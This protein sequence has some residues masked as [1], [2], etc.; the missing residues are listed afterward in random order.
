MA[1]IA[2][3][4]SLGRSLGSRSHSLGPQSTR[5]L[6]SAL[7]FAFQSIP[8]LFRHAASNNSH[9]T[10]HVLVRRKSEFN[11]H[12]HKMIAFAVLIPVLVLLSGLFAGLTLGYMS[13]DETQLNVLSVSG[14]PKQREYAKKIQPIRKNGHLLLVT[15][16]LSNMIVN[17]SLP[18]IADPVLGGGFQSVVVST[19][20]IV[21]FAE[22]I[23][24]SIF[25]RYGLYLGAKLAGLTTV[26]LYTMGIIAWP[27][28]KIL[29]FALGAHH[30]I[31]YRRAELKEL[32]ALHSTTSPHGGDLNSDTVTIIGATLDLQ[33][34]VVKQAMTPIS[35]VFMLSINSILDYET[36]KKI[37]DSGHSRIPVYEEIDTPL[38]IQV[39]ESGESTKGKPTQVISQRVQKIIGILLVKQLVLLD[40]KDAT[41]LRNV[42]LNKVFFVPNNESLLGILDKFQEG[43]SHMAVVSRFSVE[44]AKSVKKAARRGLTQRLKDRVG[45]GDSSDSDSDTEDEESVKDGDE[46]NETLNITVTSEK[47]EEQKTGIQAKD[48]A[49]ANNGDLRGSKGHKSVFQKEQ[50]MPADAVLAKSSANEF[51]RGFDPAIMPLGIITLEDVLEELIGEEIYD[52]FDADG[53]H[54]GTYTNS[55]P[56]VPTIGSIPSKTNNKAT[57]IP[58]MSFK[59]ATSAPTIPKETK[60]DVTIAP[61]ADKLLAVDEQHLTASPDQE[62]QI[63]KAVAE[64][65]KSKSL[66]TTEHGVPATKDGEVL[67]AQPPIEAVIVERKRMARAG[68]VATTTASLPPRSRV[69]GKFKSEPV[70]TGSNSEMASKQGSNSRKDSVAEEKEESPE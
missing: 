49:L 58:K 5:L 26:L 41:P 10:E 24:Q 34:K 13:L 28:A 59:R 69:K 54:G 18:V 17:E 22:I 20:L 43:H 67:T 65:G 53:A 32:I 64:E 3:P 4:R 56:A 25:T 2:S 21:I 27:V 51:L 33:E 57:K 6:Y 16:L 39:S 9:S 37:V 46:Q 29:E 15:L 66:P 44:K 42:Q 11:P 1:P 62:K 68:S 48:F 52:E 70:K 55:A 19:V 35:D 14:T 7:A 31:M 60:D 23:P 45:L 12:D 63:L 61:I 30:G 38:S 36:V 50:R 40:T 47:G 8:N